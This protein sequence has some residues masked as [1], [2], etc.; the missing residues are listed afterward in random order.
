MSTTDI[1]KGQEAFKNSDYPTAIHHLTLALKNSQSPL[2]LI[3]RST[4][5]QRTGQHEFALADADNAVI[6]A[7]SRG[8]R[9]LIA[10]AHFR[11]AVALHGLGR[12]GDARLC[13]L[14]CQKFNEKEKGVTMW[15]AKVKSDYDK[16]GGEDAECNKTTVKEVP[17][18]VEE[19]AQKAPEHKENSKPA[20]AKSEK[21]AISKSEPVVPVTEAATSAQTPKE[22]IRH[23]W[24]Q[25]TSTVT[26]EIF[27]KG[28][29]KDN[30][31]VNIQE[32]S[33]S[34]SFWW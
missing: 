30:A 7:H 28:V 27:A 25:S 24:Y 1:V 3:Q 19:V 34:S 29:P 31:E 22:K 5:Y 26:I 32:G 12:Y 4:A 14:W 8:K 15:Q 9:E 17:D 18:K 6:A 13:L 11:R 21:A 20:A 33:V 23:E 16:A 10:T 2:W